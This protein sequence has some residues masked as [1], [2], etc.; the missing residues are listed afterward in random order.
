MTIEI[1]NVMN[2]ETGEVGK[3]RRDWFENPRINA[4]VLVEVDPDQKPYAPELFRS[5]LTEPAIDPTTVEDDETE[6]PDK[7]EDE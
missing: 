7:E 1:V 6:D 5:R 4:G 3:I 2:Q